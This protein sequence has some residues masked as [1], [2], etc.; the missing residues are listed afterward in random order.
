MNIDLVS[1][2]IPL[3]E[4]PNKIS[5]RA[6]AKQL[7]V[8]KSTLSDSLREYYESVGEDGE[9]PKILIIDIETA[10]AIAA[11]FGRH[12]V[13]LTQDHIISEGGV[14]LCFGYKWLGDTEVTIRGL[15][16]QSLL[17]C[18]DEQLVVDI[19]DLFEQAD[20]IVAHNSKGFDFPMIQA[21]V[22]YHN[23]PPLPHVKV[24][25]T[26]LMAKKNFRLPNNK[27]D[28][29][30][31]FL[32]LDRKKNAGGIETWLQYMM[33]NGKAI[34]HMHDY[35]AMDVELLEKVYLRLRSFGHTG[36]EFNAAHYYDGSTVRCHVCGS[37]NVE[38]TGRDVFTA[39]SKFEEVRCNSCGAVARTRQAV[40]SREERAAIVV[41]PKV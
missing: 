36:S 34:D 37:D 29:I 20:A 26:L 23:L 8:G 11:A 32:G 19:W 12:K 38:R 10:P 39:I 3:V 16:G 41:Q 15:E 22:L 1:R 30:C 33:G 17:D 6:A 18:N 28:S 21:R 2:A 13:F 25:D 5:W 31:A 7:G 35:C 40:N 27:L 14:I 24:I 9:G 4:G